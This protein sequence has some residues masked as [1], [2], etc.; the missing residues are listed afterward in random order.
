VGL[1]SQEDNPT[2]KLQGYQW[3]YLKKNGSPER[4]ELGADDFEGNF[5]A[6]P[7]ERMGQVMEINETGSRS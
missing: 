3:L 2:S 5:V 1:S 4:L 7:E 6:V